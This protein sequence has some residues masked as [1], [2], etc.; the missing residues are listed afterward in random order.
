MR[1]EENPDLRRSPTVSTLSPSQSQS[2]LIPKPEAKEKDPQ[3]FLR[4]LIYGQ[5]VFRTSP[6]SSFNILRS[7]KL[8][9]RLT[10]LAQAYAKGVKFS[11]LGTEFYC[12]DEFVKELFYSPFYQ[13]NNYVPKGETKMQ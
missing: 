12:G 6:K 7:R 13:E 4:Q 3:N 9:E 8:G 1:Q 10:Q 2:Q 11:T 5:H